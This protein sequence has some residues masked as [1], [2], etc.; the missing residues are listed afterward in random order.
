M[1]VV[2]KRDSSM[3]MLQIKGT[4]SRQ[5]AARCKSLS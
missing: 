4:L 1:L 2:A 5:R 3:R